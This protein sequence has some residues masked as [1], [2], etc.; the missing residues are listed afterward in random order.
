MN[1]WY[2]LHRILQEAHSLSIK[3]LE[4]Q[5]TMENYLLIWLGSKIMHK[6]NIHIVII[7]QL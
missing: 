2:L 3:L 7:A 4:A 6:I 1:I 5:S